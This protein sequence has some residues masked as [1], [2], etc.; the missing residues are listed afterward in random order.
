MMK[1]AAQIIFGQNKEPFLEYA[2]KSVDWVDYYT[3]CNTA[4]N[5]EEG[6]KNFDIVKE[7][8]PID[9][10]RYDSLKL[11]E[12]DH[13]SFA[14]ARNACLDQTDEDDFVLLVDA[15]DVHYPNLEQIV[16]DCI[17]AGVDSLT[18]HFYHLM[19][20]KNLSQFVQP[21]EI[22]FKNYA[23]THF[24]KPVHEILIN[25]KTWPM[26]SDYKYMHYGYVKPQREV[27]NRW[28]FYS[29]LEGDYTHYDGQNPDTI[30]EDRISVSNI[31]PEDHPPVIQKFL[32]E[33]YEEFNP[34]ELKSTVMPYRGE[35]VG[36][37][38]ITKNDEDLLDLCLQT[39]ASCVPVSDFELLVIDIASTD[40]SVE[41]CAKYSKR[42]PMDIHK[43]K[44]ADTSL[45][46]TL[47]FGLN[48]FRSR[49]DIDYIGWIHPDMEFI[50][51]SW[52]LNL[53]VTLRT[54]PNI[55]KIC[56][57]N[58]RDAPHEGEIWEG[59]EQCYIIRKD[60]VNKIGLFDEG[61]IGI[62][63]YEDWDYNRRILMHQGYKVMT[64]LTSRVLHTGMGT[65]SRRD[66]TSEQIENARYYEQ[67]WGTNESPV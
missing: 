3:V 41:K 53:C 60:I 45:A 16:K 64:T 20:Y 63:G 18:C 4:P 22:V 37:V 10:L 54:Y 65:R 19:V 62:G 66:T 1:I 30:I 5:S 44:D 52:L 38:M 11:D 61:Y 24:E 49:A 23:G 27:F 42:I 58:T 12:H 6:L 32:N 51:R 67:K 59:H 46:E 28:K 15:D 17:E 9:K 57:Y 25:K 2:I 56:S 35:K 13:F 55:G 34:L 36:L 31:V 29:D 7:N 50:D 14:E 47:N 33:E 39:L 48:Y 43:T 8:I 21:R 26:V 40:S